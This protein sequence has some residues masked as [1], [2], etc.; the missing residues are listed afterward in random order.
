MSFATTAD[1][2]R[3]ALQFHRANDLANAQSI[4]RQVLSVE[5]NNASALHYL[6]LIEMAAGHRDVGEQMIRKSL[7]IKPDQASAWNN[8]ATALIDSNKTDEA[9]E[10]LQNA[11]RLKPENALAWQNLARTLQRGGR[12]QKSIEAS[13]KQ[14]ALQPDHPTPTWNSEL[15]NREL[16]AMEAPKQSLPAG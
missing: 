7:S 9:I 6:G 4:Y 16:A 14:L 2:L 3:V 8:L 15:C 5:P 10:A 1:A 13:R 11:V 12:V